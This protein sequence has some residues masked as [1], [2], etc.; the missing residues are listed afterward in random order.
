MPSVNHR[1]RLEQVGP[2]YQRRR[3]SRL[4]FAVAAVAAALFAIGVSSGPS[5]EESSAKTEPTSSPATTTP[6][7]RIGQNLIDTYLNDPKNRT[8]WQDIYDREGL[9]VDSAVDCTGSNPESMQRIFQSTATRRTAPFRS[10]R[11]LGV[12]TTGEII[13]AAIEATVKSVTGKRADE[14]WLAE[15]TG[16]GLTWAAKEEIYRE[17]AVAVW[18]QLVHC[19]PLELPEYIKEV[20]KQSK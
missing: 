14:V 13:N 3:G 7:K 5:P 20:P 8:T 4:P 17:Y 12:I 19:T 18:P 2:L 1:E 6:D 15:A 16:E 10:S 9:F 11:S